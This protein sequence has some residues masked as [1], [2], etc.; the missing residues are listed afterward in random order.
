MHKP[1]YPYTSPSSL[2][3]HHFKNSKKKNQRFTSQLVQLT[4]KDNKRSKEKKNTPK[5]RWEEVPELRGF[6]LIEIPRCLRP[7]HGEKRQKPSGGTHLE[8]WNFG[9]LG[10]EIREEDRE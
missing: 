8:R 9:V 1:S 2:H 10:Y 3:H 7:L 4:K 5:P 6:G